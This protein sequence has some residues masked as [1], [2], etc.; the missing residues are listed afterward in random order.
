MFNAASG[1]PSGGLI[2]SGPLSM[3]CPRCT[4][5]IAVTVLHTAS[6]PTASSTGTRS[7]GIDFPCP[8][9]HPTTATLTGNSTVYHTFPQ[10]RQRRCRVIRSASLPLVLIALMSPQPQRGHSIGNLQK[11]TTTMAP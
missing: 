3:P 2:A 5:G 9:D 10:P 1:L 4:V 11:Y 8:L 7:T 6:L